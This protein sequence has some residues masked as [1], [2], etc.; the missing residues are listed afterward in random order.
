MGDVLKCK[1]C[2]ANLC[3]C[4]DVP[5]VENAKCEESLKSWAGKFIVDNCKN[6]CNAYKILESTLADKDEEIAEL[7]NAL[8][9]KRRRRPRLYKD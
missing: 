1:N 5:I 8:R 2:G 4:A 3:A 9:K 6:H 7:K